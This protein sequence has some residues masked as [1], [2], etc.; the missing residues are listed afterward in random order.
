LSFHDLPY[1][2]AGAL[3]SVTYDFSST[4][5]GTITPNA[6]ELPVY[7]VVV[8]H[9]A[10]TSMPI[11]FIDTQINSLKMSLV[12]N[13]VLTATVDLVGIDYSL[14]DAV[15]GEQA[16]DTS[17]LMYPS[18]LSSLKVGAIDLLTEVVS[19]DFTIANNISTDLSRLDGAGR[20]ALIPG[21]LNI[22]GSFE[23]ILS[24]DDPLTLK[25]ADVGTELGNIEVIFQH[26]TDADDYIKL[27]FYNV[28]ITSISHDVNDRGVVRVNVEFGAFK[29]ASNDPLEVEFKN[30]AGSIYLPIKEEE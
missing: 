20:I 1:L 24:G 25:T 28:Y 27:T 4:L 23:A 26:P 30:T 14:T 29:D 17:I 19:F 10:G 3:G 11:T 5:E 12:S 16:M 8:R 15:T 6:S 22:T 9:G 18:V 21:E 7:D 2:L 13:A